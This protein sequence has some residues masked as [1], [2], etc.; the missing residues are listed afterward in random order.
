[1]KLSVLI[2]NYN[3]GRY[4]A[5]CIDSALS[6]DWPD[7]EVI[8]VDDG[9]TDKSREIIASYA[10]SVIPVFKSNGGQASCFNSGFAEATGDIIFML[11]A[12]DAFLPGKLAIVADA[13]D[14]FGIDWCFDH[15]TDDPAAPVPEQLG[16]LEIDKRA[17]VRRGQFPSIP[18]PTSGLSFRAPLLAQILPMPLASDVVLSDNY[19]KFAAALLG[20]GAVIDT[21]LTF[22]RLHEANRYTGSTNGHRLRPKIMVETGFHLANR[23]REM[24][25][26]GLKLVAGGLAETDLSV[27]GLA[28]EIRRC[29][30]DGTFG[31][32][33]AA[34]IAARL[35]YRRLTAPRSAVP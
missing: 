26:L 15:V 6:Q 13:Y 17:D 10:G 1:M 21:P 9:S 8:V 31:P 19:L 27:G 23:Y 29:T 3:Y 12:D 24:S 2:N 20:R 7:F 34:E 32:L 30:A 18:V 4:L 25:R 35:L 16:I 33:G 28:S 14:R 5:Q 22:Q 11:D